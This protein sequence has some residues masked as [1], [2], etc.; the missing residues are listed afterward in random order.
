MG[1]ARTVEENDH[2]D[3]GGEIKPGVYSFTEEERGAAAATLEQKRAEILDVLR[4]SKCF[5]V[6]ILDRHDRILHS[7]FVVDVE[8]INDGEPKEPVTFL[9]FAALKVVKDLATVLS[10]DMGS[11][12]SVLESLIDKGVTDEWE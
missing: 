8:G 2:L 3:V 6:S 1:G 9:C 5:T 11:A 7:S 12:L 10:I 4:A